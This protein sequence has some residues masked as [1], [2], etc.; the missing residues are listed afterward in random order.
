M[1]PVIF[2]SGV[3]AVSFLSTPTVSAYSLTALPK[4]PGLSVSPIMCYRR[5][6]V[7]PKL[8]EGAGMAFSVDIQ[9]MRAMFLILQLK[10]QLVS[11]LLSWSPAVLPTRARLNL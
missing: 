5:T 6:I 1:I 3:E 4:T 2:K 8:I 7:L 10:L 9:Q 11:S